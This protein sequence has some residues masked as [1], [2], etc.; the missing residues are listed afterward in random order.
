MQSPPKSLKGA[1]KIFCDLAELEYLTA[2]QVA[3]VGG[4]KENSRAF[5]HKT[6]QE[7]G[8]VCKV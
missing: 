2:V 6:L 8:S 7:L 3:K 5:V 4:Y 1:E